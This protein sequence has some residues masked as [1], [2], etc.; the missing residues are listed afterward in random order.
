MS[1]WH[2]VGAADDLQDGEPR[3][4]MAAGRPIAMFREGEEVFA[5]HDQCSHGAARLS[6]GYVENGCVECPLHQG[7]F[8]LRTGAPRC[9]P[10]TEPVRSY[11]VRIVGTRIEVRVPVSQTPD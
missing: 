10:V 2:D 11:A 3:A 9:L 1:E 5:L 4:V 6:D 7:L 8:D